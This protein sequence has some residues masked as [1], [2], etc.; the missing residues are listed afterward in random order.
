MTEYEELGVLPSCGEQ[1]IVWV[2]VRFPQLTD[3]D[4]VCMRGGDPLF[5]DHPTNAYMLDRIWFDIE[6]GLVQN[7][8]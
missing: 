8:P 3:D 1:H 2:G 5:E 7:D 6:F 4:W